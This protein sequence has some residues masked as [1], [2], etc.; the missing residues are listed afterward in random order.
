MAKQQRYANVPLAIAGLGLCLL[1]LAAC[2]SSGPSTH[3]AGNGAAPGAGV[4]S[5]VSGGAS[6]KTVDGCTLVTPAMLSQAV[7]AH[8][9]AIRDASGGSICS[10]TGTGPY[11]SFDY[12][13]GKEGP[14]L[15][16]WAEQIATIKQDDGSA[17]SV[18][19]I[20]D[21]AIQGAV[22]EFAVE[23]RGYIVVVI[24]ADFGNPATSKTFARTKKIER[25]LISKL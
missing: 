3:P 11:D 23:S 25:L 5:R 6:A 2:S 24:G 7:G 9:T 8:Y 1:G 16:T 21:R 4:T 10:V 22:K 18:S 15:N 19:G 14:P 17:K 12:I 20:G 13:V